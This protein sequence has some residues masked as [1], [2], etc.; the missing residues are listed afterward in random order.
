[1]SEQT[2][3]Q[4][5]KE[6]SSLLEPS[7]KMEETKSEVLHVNSR[8]EKSPVE[9]TND[10]SCSEY[11]LDTS[12]RLR[13]VST[14]HATVPNSEPRTPTT[15]GSPPKTNVPDNSQ[16]YGCSPPPEPIVP[17]KPKVFQAIDWYSYYLRIRSLPRITHYILGF[18][19][20]LVFVGNMW[21]RM[22]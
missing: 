2:S 10:L 15:D 17:L 9:P 11:E 6:N 19:V 16:S 13:K 8:R 22:R 7:V 18:G 12:V 3:N 21:Y 14:V 1:M 5:V 20:L 4:E